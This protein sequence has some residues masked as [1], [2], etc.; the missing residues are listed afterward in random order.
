MRADLTFG[1][2]GLGR[3]GMLHATNLRGGIAG[4]RL[5]EGNGLVS[6]R[7]RAESLGGALDVTSGD[8]DG[9]TIAL[10]VLHGHRIWTK[11]N[12]N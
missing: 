9:T 12:N 8:S 11:R 4:A 10:K 5:I 7:R 3:M 6:M 1:V 2:I